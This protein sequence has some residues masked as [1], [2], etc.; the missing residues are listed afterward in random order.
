MAG[1]LKTT[2]SEPGDNVVTNIDTNLQQVADSALATQVQAL[3]N[4]YDPACNNK[5]GCYPAAT[6]GA[7]VV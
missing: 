1:V 6:G 3:R 2:P 7:V 5:A 4:T